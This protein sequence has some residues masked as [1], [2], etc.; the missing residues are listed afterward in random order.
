MKISVT[1]GNGISN[2][3]L[4]LATNRYFNVGKPKETKHVIPLEMYGMV[5]YVQPYRVSFDIYN[6]AKNYR[7]AIEKYLDF[8]FVGKTIGVSM[9][10][11]C[12]WKMDL[13]K[14]NI[15]QL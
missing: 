3:K 13:P 12:E 6:H 11:E 4:L 7:E 15:F 8:L 1:S 10:T 2:R 14:V 9:P 5:V